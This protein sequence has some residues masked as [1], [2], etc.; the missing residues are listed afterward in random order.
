MHSSYFHRIDGRLFAESIDIRGFV[1]EA[2]PTPFYLYSRAQI[3]RNITLYQQAL[4]RAGFAHTLC[5]AMKANYNP[6]ILSFMAKQGLG[7]VVVNAC[8]FKQAKNAGFNAGD[9]VMHGNGKTRHDLTQAIT[10]HVLLSVDSLF[11]L[12]RIHEIA[13]ALGCQAQILLRV[14]P[15]IDPQVHPYIATALDESKFGI[16]ENDLGQAL[17]LLAHMPRIT[18]RGIHCHIGSAID[19]LAP[20]LQAQDKALMICNALKNKGFKIDTLDFGGGLGI[21][22]APKDP[23]ILADTLIDA[24]APGFKQANLHVIFEPGRSLIGNAGVIISRVI[25]VKK[26]QHKNFMVIDASMCQLL[27]PPL[28][29]AFHRIEPVVQMHD[30][31]TS[32]YDIVG[33]ICESSDVLGQNRDMPV[34]NEHDLVVIWDTGA[35]GMSM[36][37]RYN[38]QLFKAEYWVEEDRVFCIRKE[39]QDLPDLFCHVAYSA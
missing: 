29:Q 2:I 39:E 7:V 17:D 28:Y 11:D 9:M 13:T 32:V 33:P 36:A 10:H 16:A 19:S 30:A 31:R 20:F 18:L 3:L 15:H 25:G 22:Y 23:M 4:K 5:F 6:H 24:L 1:K 37:S 21:A 38:L 12:T 34:L 27:R 14:N 35:Y 26:Q 8:E